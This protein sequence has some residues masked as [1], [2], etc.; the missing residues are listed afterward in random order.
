MEPNASHAKP[1]LRILLGLATALV[2]MASVAGPAVA[3]DPP[4]PQC[5]GHWVRMLGGSHAVT[6]KPIKDLADLQ[7]RLA[8]FE[9][10]FRELI[11]RDSSLPPGVADALIAAIQSGQGVVDRNVYRKEEVRWMAYRP[12]PKT[13]EVIAP[14]CIELAKD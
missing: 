3:A 9:P 7:K 11:A 5:Q 13:L 12:A 6:H 8:E 1:V 4:A 14:P 10:G 2:L